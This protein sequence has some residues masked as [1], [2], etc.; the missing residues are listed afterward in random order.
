MESDDN[1]DGIDAGLDLHLHLHLHHDLQ[2][3]LDLDEE[4]MSQN[5]EIVEN[6]EEMMKNRQQDRDVMKV[7][8]LQ[9]ETKKKKLIKRQDLAHMKREML[10]WKKN[11]VNGEGDDGSGVSRFF[12]HSWMD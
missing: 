11:D 4:E 5:E 12:S 1:C 7:E 2:F 6:V 8:H 3:D 10:S 9:K